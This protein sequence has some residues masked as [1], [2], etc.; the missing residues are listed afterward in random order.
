M[1]WQHVFELDKG[2]YSAVETALRDYFDEYFKIQTD[3]K[4]ID[5]LN[6][7][8]NPTFKTHL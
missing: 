7:N 2:D 8:D 5:K 6:F 3:Q 1:A 4:L